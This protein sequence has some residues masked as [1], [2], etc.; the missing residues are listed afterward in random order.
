MRGAL[1]L[2]TRQSKEVSQPS[3]ALTFRAMKANLRRSM[4]SK[5]TNGGKQL[6][7]FEIQHRGNSTGKKNVLSLGQGN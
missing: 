6:T 4:V 5:K 2:L 1:S 3:N 7:Y